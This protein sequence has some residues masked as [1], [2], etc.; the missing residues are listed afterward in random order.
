MQRIDHMNDLPIINKDTV[1]CVVGGPAKPL[2][3]RAAPPKAQAT[4]P[5]ATMAINPKDFGLWKNCPQHPFR[6][7]CSDG[8]L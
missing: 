3:P 8:D 4:P 1:K 5:N 6:P 2:A 7:E